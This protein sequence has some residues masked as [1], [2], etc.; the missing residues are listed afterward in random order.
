M[1]EIL[2]Y[3]NSLTSEERAAFAVRCNTS[4]GYIRKVV[5]AKKKFGESLCIAFERETGGKVRCEM[6]RDDVDWAYLRGTEKKAA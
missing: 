1:E 3:I 6:L 5:S 4:V 2:A